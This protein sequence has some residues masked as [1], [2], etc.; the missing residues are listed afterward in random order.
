M[1]MIV[2]TAQEPTAL[3]AAVRA[4]IRKMDPNLPIP[5]VRTMREILSESV[6]QRHFQMLLTSLFAGL[7]LLLGAV[8]VYGMVSYSVACR[9][10]DIGLRLALGAVRRDVMRWV[11]A[12]GLRPVV[13]GMAV[14]LTG[15]FAIAR[16]LRSL[17]YEVTP[18]DPLSFGGV[19]GVLLLVS[20]LA[21]YLPARRAAHLDPITALRHE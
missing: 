7:S 16:A 13:F 2:K 18:A 6:A 4:E 1:T 19:A 14:G 5:T 11:L 17:L 9:V 15:A 10:R 8:G 3:A 20:A 12:F 21:C